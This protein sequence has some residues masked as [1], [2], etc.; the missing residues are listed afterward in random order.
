MHYSL[1]NGVWGGGG[2]HCSCSLVNGT[3]FTSGYSLVNN[4]CCN[5]VIVTLYT[6]IDSTHY[7][8]T[9]YI[10]HRQPCMIISVM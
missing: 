3:L 9:D 1:V 6:V 4:V 2:R 10:P 8:L 5:G 7:L